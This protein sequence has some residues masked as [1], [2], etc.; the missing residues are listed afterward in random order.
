MG[1][2]PF[3]ALLN[4]AMA[5]VL[6]SAFF[7]LWLIQRHQAYLLGI[8]IAYAAAVVGFLLQYFT[9]PIV[10]FTT[11]RF[12][13]CI[14]F[15]FAVLCL[16]ITILRHYRRPLPYLAFGALTVGGLSA[17]SWFLFVQ[18]DITWR[19]YIMNFMLGGI[20]LLVAAELWKIRRHGPIQMALFVFSLLSAASFLLRT[21]IIMRLHGPFTSFESV[22]GSSYWTTTQLAHVTL[23]LLIALSLFANCAM[24]MMGR[25]RV[26][27]HTDPLSQLL[28]RR[29]FETKGGQL[30]DRCA[31]AN[32]PV[33]LILADLDHFKSI[34]DRHG[35]AAGDRVIVDFAA[36]L[37]SAA[38]SR[39]VAGRIGGEEFAVLLPLADLGA[40]RLF[41]EAVRTLFSTSRVDG[42][43]NTK[44]TASF[45]VAARS[46]Q[47]D[48]ASM[49]G[50]AD[51]ALYQAKQSGRDGV[52][53]SFLRASVPLVEPGS[54]AFS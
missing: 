9:L 47:E 39:G 10:S 18:P 33:A 30:L 43:G 23:S 53:L 29:G 48:L 49:I 21:W 44:I 46:G 19:V 27:S 15:T 42:L 13:S 14:A 7:A 28:N 5:L 40:A 11:G 17:F 50:R 32:L 6:S 52:R 25:L 31:A 36:K 26:E 20:A 41:A 4:P 3:I 35:H 24:E 2:G 1:T 38:G 16:A 12:I 22:L 45:G 37:R 8:A 51:D 54:V 34:N